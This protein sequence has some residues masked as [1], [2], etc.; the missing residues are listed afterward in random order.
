M[1]DYGGQVPEDRANRKAY[2]GLD[3]KQPMGFT[4]Y[5]G[6]PTIAVDTHVFRVSNRLG[7]ALKKP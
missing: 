4:M 1:D 2:L 6:H 5:F 7:L 3:A